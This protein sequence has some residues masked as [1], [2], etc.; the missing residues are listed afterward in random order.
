MEGLHLGPSAQC[1][2]LPGHGKAAKLASYSPRTGREALE[3]QVGEHG[4]VVLV[5]HSLGA[6]L[7]LRYALEHADRVA[8]VCAIS[9][10]PGFRKPAAMEAWNK[11]Y[12]ARPEHALAHHDDS[13]VVDNLGRLACPLLVVVGREDA[14]FVAAAAM[15]TSKVPGAE[16]MVVEGAGHML[17][18]S[19]AEQVSGIVKTWLEKVLKQ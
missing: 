13:F 2:D 3:R 8:G 11:A 5:G 15:M 10:G 16:L 19:H 9:G 1:F 6:Y 4:M 18:V 14:D 17:P 12:S 7:S